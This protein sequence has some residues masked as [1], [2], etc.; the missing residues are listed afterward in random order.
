MNRSRKKTNAI[1]E[2]P[3]N[4][5]LYLK[6]QKSLNVNDNV[7]VNDIYKEKI[8]KKESEKIPTKEEIKKYCDERKNNIDVEQF[9]LYYSDRDWKNKDNKPVNWKLCVIT[10]EKND[11][12]YNSNKGGDSV[13]DY[14]PNL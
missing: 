5:S 8:N 10:W 4:P 2:N 14:N 9:Y 1:L 3:K 13:D 7:N 6:T 12:K 11:K